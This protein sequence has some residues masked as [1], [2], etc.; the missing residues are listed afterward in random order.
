M[1]ASGSYL[2]DTSIIIDLFAGDQ[3]V[4]Q[5]IALLDKL[6]VPSIA[7]GEL[8]Y[9][10]FK[11]QRA[12]E[13][14]EQVEAFASDNDVIDCDVRTART[15]G[16][17]KNALRITGRLIPENAIWIAAIAIQHGF[18]PLARDAHFQ[19]IEQLSVEIW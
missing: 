16:E 1:K 5:R 2:L 11:S 14:P 15:Y 3:N 18:T 10:A 13:N 8:Y 9:G 7:I 12:A 6:F 17:I 19:E 4:Q